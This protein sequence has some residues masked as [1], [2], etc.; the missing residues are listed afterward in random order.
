MQ[1]LRQL[2]GGNELI[3]APVALNP[4]MARLAEE[5][6]QELINITSSSHGRGTPAACQVWRWCVELVQ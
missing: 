2:I 6:G 1:T 4:I 5:A 3:V